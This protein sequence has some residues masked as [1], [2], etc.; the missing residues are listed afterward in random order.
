[1]DG[2]QRIDH[3]RCRHGPAGNGIAR[4]KILPR[5]HGGAGGQL[6]K[7][8]DYAHSENQRAA[9]SS[10]GVNISGESNLKPTTGRADGTHKS[11]AFELKV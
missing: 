2:T 7:R 5:I 4:L 3:G 1:M 6:I 11:V 9:I 10:F 8:S